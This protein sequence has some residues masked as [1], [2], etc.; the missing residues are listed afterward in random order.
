PPSEIYTLSL[1]DALP[2]WPEYSSGLCPGCAP[3][4][5]ASDPSS[6]ASLAARSPELQHSLGHH[7]TVR[8]ICQ[9][10]PTKRSSARGRGRKVAPADRKSTRLNSSH[11]TISY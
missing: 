5:V 4:R 10:M 8:Y 1:H 3:A 9:D 2:I 7:Y 11:R 6:R